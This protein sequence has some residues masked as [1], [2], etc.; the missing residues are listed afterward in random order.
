MLNREELNKYG[1]PGFN[2]YQKEKDYVQYWI[3]SFLS[4]SGFRG[5]FKGGTALQK[6]F[7]LPRFSE[8]LNFTLNENQGPDND[9]ITAFLSSTGFQGM[10]W[11]GETSEISISN[12]LRFKGPLYNGNVVSEGTILMEFSKREKVILEPAQ[13]MITPP[14]PDILPYQ[15]NVMNKDEMASEK[16]RA[17]L[18]RRSARDLFDLYFLMRQGVRIDKGMIEKKLEYYK[19][20]FNKKDTE[21]R[22]EKLKG[23]W[24]KEISLLTTNFLEYE[25]VAEEVIKRIREA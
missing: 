14:Y 15:L 23:M 2:P 21:S 18:T 22:I 13:I 9:A 3:L 17:I 7:G 16:V 10:S 12:K 4:Q 19:I 1:P 6:A 5:I 24:K 8:D 20:Q 11:K 25:L